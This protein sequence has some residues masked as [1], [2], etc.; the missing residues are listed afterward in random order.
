MEFNMLAIFVSAFTTFLIGFVW[1]HPKVFGTIWMA[2]SGMTEEKA[3][4]GNMAKIFSLT[5]LYSFMLAFIMPA[6]TNHQMGAFGMIGGFD[7]LATAKPS[8]AAF[9][10]DYGDAF[11]TFKHGALHG[12]MSGVFLALPIIAINSLFE[13]KSWKYIA[14]HAGYFTVVMTTIGAIVCGWK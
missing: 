5:F 12:F 2:E 1:Y 3:K 8:Y 4:K 10:A 7:G 6:L 9:M 14:I 11:R 13:Q